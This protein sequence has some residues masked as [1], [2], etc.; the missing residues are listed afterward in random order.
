MPVQ[1]NGASRWRIKLGWLTAGP[2]GSAGYWYEDDTGSDHC[3]RP[4]Q[5]FGGDLMQDISS[6]APQYCT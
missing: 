3:R 2:K 1:P 6:L 4:Y 5:N